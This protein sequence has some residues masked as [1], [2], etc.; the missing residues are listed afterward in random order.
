MDRQARVN[1][2]LRAALDKDAIVTSGALELLDRLAGPRA[3]LTKDVDG[4]ARLVMSEESFD[5]QSVE[6]D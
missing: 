6:W 3:C 5:L 1:P 4:R 2:G